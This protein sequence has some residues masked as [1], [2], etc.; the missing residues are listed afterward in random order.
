VLLL[1]QLALAGQPQQPDSSLPELLDR[2]KT[3]PANA[4]LCQQIGLAYT[5]SNDFNHAA[6][7]FRKALT[8][9]PQNIPSA[10]D[11]GTVLWFAGQKV[12]SAAIFRSLEK[13]TPADP[14]PQLYLGLHAY[15]LKDMER[16]AVHFDRAGALASDNPD[17]LPVV[18]ST[19]LVTGRAQQAIEILERRCAAGDRDPQIYR[20]LG[21]AYDRQNLPQNAWDAYSKAIA[22][23]PGVEE[24]YL[25]LA[26]FAIEHKNA[27]IA[28]DV[29][30]R[31]LVQLPGSAKL[32]LETG[33]VWALEGNF[34]QAKKEFRQAGSLDPNWSLPL[35]A[36]GITDLQT[37]DPGD[38]A[39]VFRRAKQ[40]ARHDYRCY[41]FHA[42][43]LNRSQTSQS[44]AV[45]SQAIE[46]LHRA[47]ALEP[48]R[49]QTRVALA[50]NLMS[51]GL[52]AEAE[53]QLR[54][55]IRLD[56]TEPTAVY[57]L[58]LLCK[59][60][61]KKEEADRLLTAFASLKKK[62]GADENEFV[63]LAQ[64]IR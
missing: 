15:D 14:V 49:A 11:L 8:I 46:E 63:L 56:P 6:E 28:R 34:D 23:A 37:G 51:A 29:L 52:T 4:R 53:A 61:G 64:N 31:G 10:K 2:Y 44:P 33:L 19:F 13:K 57:K 7:F 45:R 58:A 12:E 59:R 43:A 3:E 1:L 62:A 32:I 60:E 17:V 36:L 54:E 26:A 16:A 42:L 21:D 55:A 35:L 24:N 9:D 48:T 22:T 41:Y 30:G 50:Q 25:T 47:I 39:E 27:S 40:I 20:W 18:V 5:K 38:A